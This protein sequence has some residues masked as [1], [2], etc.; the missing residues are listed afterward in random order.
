[1]SQDNTIGGAIIL[2]IGVVALIG[3][4]PLGIVLIILGLII[5]LVTGLES[6]QRRDPPQYP[7]QILPQGFVPTN[8]SCRTCNAGLWWSYQYQSYFCPHCGRYIQ[9]SPPSTAIPYP[10][11]EDGNEIFCRYCGQKIPGG[12]RFCGKC[13]RAVGKD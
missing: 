4:L 8:Y 13:G 2:I 10:T 1:M 3:C 9:P 6:D 11:S 5:I 12:S 7:Y